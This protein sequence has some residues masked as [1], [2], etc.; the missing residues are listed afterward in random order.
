MHS[1]VTSQV[2]SKYAVI[3]DANVLEWH[4]EPLDAETLSPRSLLVE[5]DASFVSAGTELANFTGSDPSNR[6]AG[7]WN[8]Y[9][10]RPGYAVAGRVLAVGSA[11]DFKPGDRVFCYGRHASHQI[12]DVIPD[13][14]PWSGAFKMPDSIS[15]AQASVLRLALIAITAPQLSVINPGDTV[16]V[17]GLGLIGNLA[18]QLYQIAGANVIGLDPNKS[19][20]ELAKRCGISTVANV[21]PG[22]QVEAIRFLTNNKGAAITVDAVGHSAVVMNALEAT[23]TFGQVVLL[24]TPR[25]PYNTDVTAFL[26]HIHLRWL[27]VRG[28]LECHVPTY[29]THGAAH[30]LETNFARLVDWTQQGKLRVEPLISHVIRPEGLAD[31]YNKL[32][33]DPENTWGVVIDW[34]APAE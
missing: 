27:T 11:L 25:A 34:T 3:A 29:K 9:P 20:C 33:N 23:A 7:S 31:A 17:F 13:L 16:A 24:G 15:A 5:S 21:Q 18:A 14:N 8:A 30:S 12:Y 6:E 26:R 32:L 22:D 28:A 10:F 2:L 19:R 1:P 4:T